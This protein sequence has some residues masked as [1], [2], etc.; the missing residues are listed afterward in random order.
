MI[1]T[2]GIMIPKCGQRYSMIKIGD[3]YQGI[4]TDIMLLV[5]ETTSTHVNCAILWTHEST[6]NVYEPLE[7]DY[8]PILLFEK[9]YRKLL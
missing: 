4:G 8:W 3:V 5:I 7:T 2:T 6:I 9:Y 1:C